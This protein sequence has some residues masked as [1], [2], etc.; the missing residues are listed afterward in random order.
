MFGDS[1]INPF[2]F[3]PLTNK[4]KKNI[5]LAK[6]TI[7]ENTKKVV[8]G[9]AECLSSDMFTKYREDYLKGERALIEAGIGLSISNPIEYAFVAQTIFNN[10]K[11]LKMLGDLVNKDGKV[12]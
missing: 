9:A 11:I 3:Q 12:K 8:D 5:E 6:R 4:E 2:S 1:N 10:L 7:D